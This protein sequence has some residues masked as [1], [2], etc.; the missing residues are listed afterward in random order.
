MFLD[1][2]NEWRQP[3]PAASRRRLTPREETIMLWSVGAFLVSMVVA[4]IGG[5]TVIH[6][7]LASFGL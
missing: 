7:L 4:P 5:A 1:E 3:E 6:A 2:K